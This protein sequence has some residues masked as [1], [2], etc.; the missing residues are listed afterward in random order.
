MTM[1]GHTRSRTNCPI[2]D[3]RCVKIMEGMARVYMASQKYCR[4]NA[5]LLEVLGN[6]ANHHHSDNHP[7]KPKFT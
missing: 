1:A 7:G 4:M 5:L 6:Q 2:K 3:A